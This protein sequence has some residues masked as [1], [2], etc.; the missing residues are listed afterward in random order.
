MG[1]M[2]GVLFLLTLLFLI[3]VYLIGAQRAGGLWWE[4]RGSGWVALLLGKAQLVPKASGSLLLPRLLCRSQ[5]VPCM[6]QAPPCLGEAS[7]PHIFSCK[8]PGHWGR[9]APSPGSVPTPTPVLNLPHLFVP[10]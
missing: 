10:P 9:A 7:E 1:S 6:G 2:E 5:E 8:Q 4:G 3:R